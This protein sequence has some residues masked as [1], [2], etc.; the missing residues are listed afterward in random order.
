MDSS[1]G[2]QHPSYRHSGDST[3]LA[4]QQGYGTQ[5]MELP[6][7]H[8]HH[9]QQQLQ[10]QQQQQQ[11]SYRQPMDQASQD[12]YLTPPQYRE[13]GPAGIEGNHEG[14]MLS[15]PPL[16]NVERR[17]SGSN[18]DFGTRRALAANLQMV[19]PYSNGIHRPTYTQR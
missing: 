6:A 9:Q 13:A 1:G 18:V 14:Q 8:T 2:S 10:Q 7:R 12:P 3:Q 17:R 15:Y 19:E 5:S 4:Q 16:K 11:A